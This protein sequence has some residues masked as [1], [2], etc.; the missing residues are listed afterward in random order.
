MKVINMV[1]I[2]ILHYLRI[3]NNAKKTYIYICLNA[4][5]TEIQIIN[6]IQK[7]SIFSNLGLYVVP[8]YANSVAINNK[9][10]Y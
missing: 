10:N 7:L 3:R 1:L 2:I 8:T 4:K 5:K 9:Q 6:T